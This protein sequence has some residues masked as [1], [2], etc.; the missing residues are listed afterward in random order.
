[1]CNTFTGLTTGALPHNTLHVKHGLKCSRKRRLTLYFTKG[2]RSITWAG[3]PAMVFMLLWTILRNILSDRVM[4][5]GKR[6]CC[7]VFQM[8]FID[9]WCSEC[10][11]VYYIGEMSNNSIDDIS[12][13]LQ[14]KPK[15]CRWINIFG[16][17]LSFKQLVKSQKIAAIE[18]LLICYVTK[19]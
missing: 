15:Q 12:K 18:F 19:V 2:Q 16:V 9:V 13:T 14:L 17:N 1:M 10:H 8:Y 5:S 6:H 7:E 11:L 3:L 4:I